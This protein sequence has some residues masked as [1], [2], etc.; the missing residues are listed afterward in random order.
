MITNIVG[1]FGFSLLLAVNKII[2]VLVP[3]FTSIAGVF[4]SRSFKKTT[5]MI[6]GICLILGIFLDIGLERYKEILSERRIDKVRKEYKPDLLPI[7]E[8]FYDKY[9]G[10]VNWVDNDT[11]LLAEMCFAEGVEALTLKQIAKARSYFKRSVKKCEKLNEKPFD[12][13]KASALNNLIVVEY[14]DPLYDSLKEH[15]LKQMM[16]Y[17]EDAILCSPNNSFIKANLNYVK[18]HMAVYSVLKK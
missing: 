14:L 17:A 8:D 13:L 18:L 3:F 4:G 16:E 15:K 5:F 9:K 1:I 2:Y 12:E 6:C 10:A 7:R 11:A